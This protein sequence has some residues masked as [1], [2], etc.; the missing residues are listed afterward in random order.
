[1]E[2]ETKYIIIFMLIIITSFMTG[3]E[4]ATK[5]INAEEA[6]CP[7]DS[8]C[9]REPYKHNMMVILDVLL[10]PGIV[11]FLIIC[12]YATIREEK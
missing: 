6:E 8:S 12:M 1:M 10:V 7:Q 11:L 9:I 5:I 3:Y 2:N 4:T